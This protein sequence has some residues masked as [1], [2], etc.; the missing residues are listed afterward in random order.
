M[1][2][3]IYCRVSSQRQV[4]E[5]HGNDTQEKRCIDLANSKNY[6]VAKTFPDNGI[7]GGLFDRPAMKALLQYI[8]DHPH[9][10][11][12]VIFDDLARFAR[13]VG[14]HIQLKAEFASRGV[15]LLCLNFNFEDSPESEYAELVLAAGN[16]Y[17][18]QSNKRQVMQKMKARLERGYWSFMLPFGLINRKDS[19]HGKIATPREPYATI[20]KEAIEK[21]RDGVLPTTLDVQAFVNEKYKEHDIKH[22]MSNSSAKHILTTILYAGYI[23]YPKWGIPRMKAQHEGFISLET[24]ELVLERLQG[25]AKPWHRK[26]YHLDFPLRPFVLCDKCGVPMSASYNTA[27]GGKRYPHYYCRGKKENCEYVWKTTLKKDFEKQFEVLLLKVKPED[28]YIDLAKDVLGEQWGI[29][30]GQY[31]DLNTIITQGTEK[32]EAAITTYLELIPTTKNEELRST[33]EDEVL[34]L[35]KKLK[36]EMAKIGKRKYTSEE[37]GTASERV[38]NTLKKP[39]SL[40]KSEDYNDKRTILFMYFENELRYDYKR[41]FGTAGLAYPVNLI[42]QLGQAKNRS[43]EMSMSDIESE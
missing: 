39:M 24:H 6:P 25:R 20:Y 43:V 5:G 41:G 22:K 15:K 8:D 27:R 35:K 21:Y 18:R 19:V 42:S 4:N 28:E 12:V 10:E 37:F 36:E 11:Y 34:K 1:K 33:Y 31:L 23:E 32:I 29:R 14:V 40:W 17:H 2:A 13:D 7:S 3:L 38:L 30:Q 9:E 16:Q 26:D